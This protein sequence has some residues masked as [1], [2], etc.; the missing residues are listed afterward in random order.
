MIVLFALLAN[1]DGQSFPFFSPPTTTSTTTVVSGGVPLSKS[2]QLSLSDL[3]GLAATLV[4]IF[5]LLLVVGCCLSVGES[6]WSVMMAVYY[7]FVVAA[8]I[9][10][11]CTSWLAIYY[12]HDDDSE[13]LALLS[14]SSDLGISLSYADV[15]GLAEALSPMSN[16]PST[17]SPEEAILYLGP[18]CVT[19]LAIVAFCNFLALIVRVMTMVSNVRF[20]SRMCKFVNATATVSVILLLLAGAAGIAG[21]AALAATARFQE[22]EATLIEIST[23][24][25]AVMI[26]LF[27]S[28]AVAI[29]L[30]TKPNIRMKDT[31]SSSPSSSSTLPTT[32]NAREADSNFA[33]VRA[34][35]SPYFESASV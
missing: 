19:L 14:V 26:A 5:V 12:V 6:A 7:A 25:F 3:I 29:L 4:V 24:V 15:L 1:V 10:G 23:G 27:A 33:S 17:A 32:M 31:S 16:S 8:A 28:I 21:V 9:V 13:Y 2:S 30:C 18:I 34:E 22:D 20:H 35:S 11:T